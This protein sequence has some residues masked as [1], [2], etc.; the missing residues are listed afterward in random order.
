MAPGNEVSEVPWGLQPLGSAKGQRPRGN[1][2][3]RLVIKKKN[4]GIMMRIEYNVLIIIYIYIILNYILR[5]PSAGKKR[6][7]PSWFEKTRWKTKI[8]IKPNKMR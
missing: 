4:M 5:N 6:D 3:E 7:G 1:P 2:L 8:A